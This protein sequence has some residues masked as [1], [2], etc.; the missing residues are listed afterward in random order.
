MFLRVNS[1]RFNTQ[2]VVFYMLDLSVGVVA[3]FSEMVL[4]V[5]ALFIHLHLRTDVSC[6]FELLLFYVVSWLFFVNAALAYFIHF[7]VFFVAGLLF[8]SLVF[9]LERE[10]LNNASSWLCRRDLLV[11]ERHEAVKEAPMSGA[12]RQTW[13]RGVQA[14]PTPRV[15][16]RPP[17]PVQTGGGRSVTPS[18]TQL[19]ALG[20]LLLFG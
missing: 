3:G 1:V 11:G 7:V 5:V 10:P 6:A 4:Y 17:R 13:M 12:W 16:R 2:D 19:L 18:S 14:V 15:N 8:V 9:F 20:R